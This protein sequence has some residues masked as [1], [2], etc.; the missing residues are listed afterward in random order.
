MDYTDAKQ[1][2]SGTLTATLTGLH[3]FAGNSLVNASGS[4]SVTYDFSSTSASGKA[5]VSIDSFSLTIGGVLQVT[6]GP[7]TITPAPPANDKFSVSSA[8]L[9]ET[10]SQTVTNLNQISVLLTTGSGSSAVTT[11][12]PVSDYTVTG[13]TLTFKTA[14]GQ[15]GTLTVVYPIAK[16]D[17]ATATILPLNLSASVSGV[18]ISKTGISVTNAT[19]LLPDVSIGGLLSITAPT[20]SFSNVVFQPGAAGGGSTFSGDAHFTSTHAALNLGSGL[21]ISVDHNPL[22]TGDTPANLALTGDYDFGSKVLQLSLE[23]VTAS[24]PL[25]NLDATSVMFTYAPASDSATMLLGAKNVTLNMAVGGAGLQVS[26]AT[27]A[28]EVFKASGGPIFYAL[29]AQ[30]TVALVGMPANSLSLSGQMEVRINTIAGGVNVAVP[31]SSAPNDTMLLSFTGAHQEIQGADLTLMVGGVVSVQGNFYATNSGGKILV[32]ITGFSAFLGTNDRSMGVHIAG[33]SMGLEICNDPTN[34]LVYALD[35]SAT[36]ISVVGFGSFSLTGT[37]ELKVNTTGGTVTDSIPVAGGGAAFDLSLGATP[38]SLGGNLALDIAGFVSLEGAFSF[39]RSAPVTLGTVTTTELVVVAT[40]VQAFMGAE[41]PTDPNNNNTKGIKLTGGQLGLLLIK[42]NDV[43]LAVQAAPAYALDASGTASLQGFSGITLS[44]MTFDVRANTTGAALTRTLSTSTGNVLL[45]FT[46]GSLVTDVEGTISSSNPFTVSGFV[47][48]SGS[49]SFSK[50]VDPVNSPT[51]T[52]LLVGASG[53]TATWGSGT[54]SVQLTNGTLALALYNDTSLGTP[55]SYALDVSGT[56]AV[57]GIPDL[58]FSGSFDARVNTRPSTVAVNE[59]INVG[60]AQLPLAFVAGTGSTASITGSGVTLTV[61]SF[62]TVS[63]S[64][65]VQK[66]GSDFAVG[67]SNVSASVGVTDGSGFTGVK[68]DGASFGLLVRSGGY[69]VVVNGGTDTLQGIP[70][71]SLSASNLSIRVN[72]AGVIT[73]Q[74]VGGVPIEFPNGNVTDIEGSATVSIAGFVDIGGSFAFRTS[75][76]SVSGVTTFIIGANAVT[77]TV[78]TSTV[79]LS[80]TLANLGLVVYRPTGVAATYALAA[81]GGTATFNGL[82]DFPLAPSVS[83]SDFAVK[84]NNTGKSGAD[85]LGTGNTTISTPGGSVDF[86]SVTA[87]DLQEVEGSVNGVTLG[88]FVKV[89]GDFAFSKQIVNDN[90]TKIVVA[91][92]NVTAFAG[93]SD[94]SYG[95]EVSGGKLGLA[96]F[97]NSKTQTTTYA[98]NASGSVQLVGFAASDL[99]AGVTLTATASV[100]INTTGV[101]VSESI[102]TAGGVVSIAFTDGSNSTADQRYLKAFSGSLSFNVGGFLTLSGDFS[103]TIPPPLGSVSRLLIGASNVNVA[104]NDGSTAASISNGSFGLVINRD[105]T[106]PQNP[107]TTFALIATGTVNVAGGFWA[108]ATIQY[109]NGANPR[110]AVAAGSS[111]VLVD[112]TAGTKA[113]PFE[114]VTIGNIG[115]SIPALDAVLSKITITLSNGGLTGTVTSQTVD[116]LAISDVL[117]LDGLTF[118]GTLT[119]ASTSGNWT[120]DLSVTVDSATLFPNKSFSATLVIKS[121]STIHFGT[122]GST[123]TFQV[124]LNLGFRLA[125]GD[126]LL[127]TAGDPDHPGNPGVTLSYDSTGDVHQTIMDLSSGPLTVTSPMFGVTGTMTGL[128]VYKDGFKFDSVSISTTN[129]VQIGGVLSASSINLSAGGFAVTYGSSPSLTGGD[130]LTVTVTGLQLFPGGFF[131][132][133]VNNGGSVI[134]TYDFSNFTASNGVGAA[135]RFSLSIPDGITVN[136]GEAFQLVTGAITITPG[137]QVIASLASATLSFPQFSGLGTLTINNLQITQS[138]FSLGSVTLKSQASA[139]PG[140]GGFLSFDSLTVSL[141]TFF[142]N[143]LT[144]YDQQVAISSATASGFQVALSYNIASGTSVTAQLTTSSGTQV[145]DPSQ[146]TLSNGVVTFNT[147]LAASSTLQLSYTLDPTANVAAADAAN[148]TRT[149]RIGGSNNIAVANARLFPGSGIFNATLGAVTGNYTFDSTNHTTQLSFSIQNLN[150]TLCDAIFIHLGNVTLTPGLPSSSP[151]TAVILSVP[152]ATIDTNLFSGLGSVQI[153]NFKLYQSGFS[154]SNLTMLPGKSVTD[155]FLIG[156]AGAQS[157][158]TLSQTPQDAG[159]VTVVLT[160][161]DSSGVTHNDLVPVTPPSGRVLTLP[162]LA[163]AGTLSVTYTTGSSTSLSIGN[164]LQVT[165]ASLTLSNFAVSTTTHTITGT[166]T[167]GGTVNLFPSA[168]GS[169]VTM[170]GTVDATLDFSK[171]TSFVIK[172]TGFKLAVGS[173]LEIDADTVTIDPTSTTLVTIDTATA[174]ILPM[175]IGATI[176]GLAITQTGFT[177]DS[178]NFQFPNN[179][180]LGGGVLTLTAPTISFNHVAFSAGGSLTGTVHFSTDGA[181]L[182]LGDATAVVSHNPALP[183]SEAVSGDYDIGART[184]QLNLQVVHV[185]FLIISVDATGVSLFYQATGGDSKLLLGA[186]GVSIAA[187]VAGGPQ[188]RITSGT[189]ALAVF[190]NSTT[191]TTTY[192]LDATGGFSI[193]GLPGD[194]AFGASK[195]EARINNTGLPVN[196]SV[197]VNGTLLPLVFGASETVTASNIGVSGVNTTLTLVNTPVDIGKLAVNVVVNGVSTTLA[198]STYTVG[199][200]SGQTV[201]TSSNYS[202]PAGAVVVV[203][204]FA[205]DTSQGTVSQVSVSGVTLKIGSAVSVTGTFSFTQSGSG[206]AAK[207]LIGATNVTASIGDSTMGVSITNGTFGMELYEDPTSG[208]SVYALDASGAVSVYGF[209]SALKFNVSSA[210]LQVNNTGAPVTNVSIPTTGAPVTLNLANG[211]GSVAFNAQGVTL[212][213]AGFATI[214]GSFSFSQTSSTSAG[215]ATT[216]IQVGATVQTAFLGVNGTGLTLTG[217]QLGLVLFRRPGAQPTYALVATATNFSLDGVPGLT[218]TT[219]GSVAGSGLAIR[220]N[221]TGAALNRTAAANPTLPVDVVFTDGTDGTADQRQVMDIEGHVKLVVSD[222]NQPS[223]QFAQLTGDF[224]FSQTIDPSTGNNKLLAGATN[225]NVSVGIS[226]ATLGITNGTMALAVYKNGTGTA[227]ATYALDLS[228]QATLSI[229]SGDGMISLATDNTGELELRINNTGH[230]INETVNVNGTAVP[231][232]FSGSTVSD[233]LT[234]A[235]PSNQVQLSQTPSDLGSITATVTEAVTD[236]AFTLASGVITYTLD[237]TVASGST[238]TV[239]YTNGGSPTTL[240]LGTDFTVSKNSAGNMVLTFVNTPP[241]GASITVSYSGVVNYTNF[242]YS[243]VAGNPALQLGDTLPAGAVVQVSY[244]VG[245]TNITQFSATGMKLQVGSFATVSGDFVFRKSGTGTAA[246]LEV[247]AENLN[248]SV[249]AMEGSSFTGLSIT[250][251]SFGMVVYNDGYALMV[252]GGVDALVGIP[253]LTVTANGLVVKAITTSQPVQNYSIS[254]PGST[255][256]VLN[257]TESAGFFEAEGH[258]TLGVANLGSISGDFGVQK[259]ADGGSGTYLAIG[260]NNV[261]VVLGTSDTNF[262]IVGASLGILVHTVSGT[263]TYAMITSG[264]TDALNGVPDL[265]FTG[266]LSLKFNNG[267][268]TSA[269]GIPTSVETANGNV[270]LDFSSLGSGTHGMSIEGTAN[271][272]IAGFFTITNGSFVIQQTTSGTTTKII[273]AVSVPDAYMGGSSFGLD[274]KNVLF[275]LVIYRDSTATASTYALNASVG[276]VTVNG[277][278]SGTTLSGSVSLA[279]NTTNAAVHEVV[280]VSGTDVPIDFTDGTNGSPD[281]RNFKSLG[282][283]LKFTISDGNDLNFVLSGNFS[284]SRTVTG[285]LTTTLI[286]ASDV[287]TAIGDSVSG[288]GVANVSITNG[289]LGLAIYSDSSKSASDNSNGYALF[290]SATANVSVG[291]GVVGAKAVLTVRQ[292]STT[293]T[294]NE[295]I[296]VGGAVVPVTFSSTEVFNGPN[297]PN[298]AF[299]DVA[300]GNGSLTIANLITL[301]AGN[302]SES[303]NTYTATNATITFNDPTQPS[304]AL[305]TI[306]AGS[307]TYTSGAVWN[308]V[309]NNASLSLG[310]FVVISAG[311]LRIYPDASNSALTHISVTNGTLALYYNST[312]Y[313]SITASFSFHFG[314]TDG[315]AIDGGAASLLTSVTDFQILPSLTGGGSAQSQATPQTMA[316]PMASPLDDSSATPHRLGPLTLDTPTFN[317][318]DFHFAPGGAFSIRLSIG[319]SASLAIGSSVTA[320]FTNLTLAFN[321]GFKINLAHP[322]SLPTNITFNNFLVTVG[323]FT[324]TIGPDQ[325]NPFLTLSANNVTINPQAGANQDLISFGGGSTPATYGLSATLNAGPLHLQGGASNFAIEGNGSLLA[326]S[327]FLVALAAGQNTA[328]AVDWPSWLPISNLSVTLT[329]ADFN[330][331][332]DQFVLTLS[333]EVEKP[334]FLPGTVNFSG[335]VTGLQINV[336]KL[337]NGEFPIVGIGSVGVSVSGTLFGGPVSASLILGIAKF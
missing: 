315:F 254:I 106:D 286:G 185:D 149:V 193:S 207:L 23:K 245:E 70:G 274:F 27:L 264:G 298:A 263:T 38:L 69:A 221:T 236:P 178:V 112:V 154:I 58:G 301:T 42:K 87:A 79:N 51:L 306:S 226:S 314:G 289:Q 200:V 31:L 273:V 159:K 123:A 319:D 142:Y 283:S 285:T 34:G 198:P 145:I 155:N 29:D 157:P 95:L 62:A 266:T 78:G 54:A 248:L 184:L 290:V 217:G 231:L 161:T 224:V 304:Q 293:R 172:V 81:S 187:G 37:A 119:R 322:L 196:E 101:A 30:G 6:A 233:T 204:Y 97:A 83:A 120:G 147:A 76:N 68:L 45:N 259:T 240:R 28:L 179:I 135:G 282:G 89:S 326:K 115:T 279:I 234:L 275:G 327:N 17:N 325:N 324:V 16:I 216:E 32:S 125:L 105:A 19:V 59:T 288:G 214:Q 321:L 25:V 307:I 189:L 175:G 265:T 261:N 295:S 166:L 183:G 41:D 220:I 134:G 80:V 61:G 15:V 14:L 330:N 239:S 8:T 40:G 276:S 132:T 334:S 118:N 44:G 302:I 268:D 222:P 164:F 227:D 337:E 230:L 211:N 136:M 218:L 225:V 294:V 169:P 63:G 153:Q 152:A 71:L 267:I 323:N 148:A 278:P 65:A 74:S 160:W 331:H 100:S 77:A 190:H 162:D 143:V 281:Q 277:L 238:P 244:V 305:F 102:Q 12:V 303:G 39:S 60:G 255:P 209:G 317:F 256:I 22:N 300:V 311:S 2:V 111:S 213:I 292:N 165:G 249:G 4:G 197:N 287:H 312:L 250:G 43:S 72:T 210:D 262:T 177:I 336:A 151:D 257:F 129:P 332:P 199:T 117:Q 206:A 18:V 130:G 186:T 11:V 284:F 329:W 66:S 55:A 181:S 91:A 144:T 174:S 235:N 243:V 272:D 86:S 228:G 258:I 242:T 232:V 176:H 133:S 140:I 33:G 191:S 163:Q 131:T 229:G 108:T 271:L 195:V 113:A 192:A 85:L 35:A 320:S 241:A 246:V 57:T 252:N 20:L 170:S 156:T 188:L 47:S 92:T 50:V 333:A 335:S 107:V 313:V 308:L 10:L 67:A 316:S 309:V 94:G 82:A 182:N 24:L 1:P 126:A 36:N 88:G 49:F 247:G 146:Y 150:I 173:L 318:S 212:M 73:G 96:I 328:D 103:L 110:E 205:G 5:T 128:V 7:V 46:D 137:Q 114:Q 203:G 299:T 168:S 84:F 122:N 138:G 139:V 104:A 3:L 310:G 121:G 90:V 75:T 208:K 280:N 223:Q 127:I 270:A 296:A 99:G 215:A 109:N 291:G 219:D 141:N 237:Q 98:L 56:L 158:V 260:V 180:S 9:T 13:K 194:L 52:K 171:T 167:L 269:A 93:L 21:A 251:A 297:N 253:D 124:N 53:V 48:L 116:H 64:F 202:L 201:I 26:N